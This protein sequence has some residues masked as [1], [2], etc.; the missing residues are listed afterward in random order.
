MMFVHWLTAFCC[1][2]LLLAFA[3]M[4]GRVHPLPWVTVVDMEEAWQAVFRSCKTRDAKG[5]FQ[6]LAFDM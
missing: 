6:D 4:P 2:L 3:A 1:V 5:L